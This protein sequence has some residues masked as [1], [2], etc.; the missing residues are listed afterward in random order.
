MYKKLVI[1]VICHYKPCLEV[2]I[3]FFASE[4][5]TKLS[6]FSC[7]NALFAQGPSTAALYYRCTYSIQFD[8]ILMC[9]CNLIL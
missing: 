7:I 5:R 1:N 3:A 6:S 8:A 4:F 2:N 9:D